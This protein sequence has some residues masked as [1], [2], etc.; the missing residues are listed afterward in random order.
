MKRILL[1][2][3]ALLSMASTSVAQ[4]YTISTSV[5]NDSGIQSYSFTLSYD[6]MGNENPL[7]EPIWS[8]VFAI[9]TDFGSPTDIVCPQGW[10][11]IYDPNWGDCIWF[12]E[13]PEGWAAGDFGSNTIA[14]RGVLSGFS[15]KTRLEP[16]YGLV[17]ATDT[18]FVDDY[19]IA[20]IPQV[21][22]VPEPASMAVLGLSLFSL[23]T[24]SRRR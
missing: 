18:A 6:Q 21:S 17:I 19:T 13:G 23:V 12:T 22:P 4:S 20:T 14:P 15:F 3:V 16:A 8:W 10:Q 11:F 7:S 5:I 2:A 1:I 9:P 24:R